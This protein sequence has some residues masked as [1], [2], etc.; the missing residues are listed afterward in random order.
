MLDVKDH[1]SADHLSDYLRGELEATAEDSVEAHIGSCLVCAR[2]L[3]EE[4]QL[5]ML[6]YEAHPTFE[7]QPVA[8][9]PHRRALWQRVAAT[10]ANT[11]AAAAALVL[12]INPSQPLGSQSNSRAASHHGA[13]VSSSAFINDALCFPSAD[14]SVSAADDNCEEPLAVSMASMVAMVTDPDDYL[15]PFDGPL[16]GTLA[17]RSTTLNACLVEDLACE[18]S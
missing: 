11:A 16:D 6:L 2:R 8:A 1:V 18:P 5:E 3:R 9:Q 7:S 14:A 15:S 17:G 12:V 10:V 13:S 4:A